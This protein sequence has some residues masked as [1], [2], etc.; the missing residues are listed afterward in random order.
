M[1]HAVVVQEAC[2]LTGMMTTRVVT[3]GQGK[4]R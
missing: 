3:E 4:V 2:V 1:A